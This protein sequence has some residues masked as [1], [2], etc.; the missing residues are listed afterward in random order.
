MP[1]SP[2]SLLPLKPDVLHIL[3]ALSGKPLHG[4]AIIREVEERS[5]GRLL[6]QTGALYRTLRQLL[7]AELIAEADAPPDEASSD[8]RRRYYA[9][10]AFGRHVLEAEADRM[11]AL[12]RAARLGAAGR[13]AKLT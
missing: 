3:L 8:E 12:A 1:Q 4:Y 2:E 11:T 9:V 5:A 13:K 7:R 6:L 10:T